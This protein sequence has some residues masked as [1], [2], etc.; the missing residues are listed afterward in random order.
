MKA[1]QN[2]I[3]TTCLNLSTLKLT[4]LESQMLLCKDFQQQVIWRIF[5]I[6]RL[7]QVNRHTSLACLVYLPTMS[8]PGRVSPVRGMNTTNGATMGR[9]GSGGRSRDFPSPSASQREIIYETNS[10]SQNTKLR[11]LSGHYFI[12]F[13]FFRCPSTRAAV[14]LPPP[15]C[16][17]FY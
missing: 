6:S 2:Q 15:L 4:P 14:T 16:I 12:H 5:A 1:S 10:E 3:G 13:L 7:L 17:S 8:P 9:S 11:R